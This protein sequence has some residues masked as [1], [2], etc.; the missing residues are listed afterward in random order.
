VA[1][2]RH[3][4][5]SPTIAIRWPHGILDERLMRERY[6][7]ARAQP[8]KYAAYLRFTLEPQARYLADRVWA[9]AH[10][11]GSVRWGLN[12]WGARFQILI[13]EAQGRPSP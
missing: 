12:H 10:R 3:Y 8:V 5:Y 11:S 1:D 6:D 4:L 7:G 2:P 13:G 9:L